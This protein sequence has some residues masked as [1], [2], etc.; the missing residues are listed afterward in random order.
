MFGSVKYDVIYN[1]I[2]YLIGVKSGIKYVFSQYYT[3]FKV[4]SYD[5]LPIKKKKKKK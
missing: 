4:G 2:R 3:K 1:G 5:S